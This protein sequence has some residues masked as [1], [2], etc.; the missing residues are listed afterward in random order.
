MS[1]D[2]YC[3]HDK[4]TADDETHEHYSDLLRDTDTLIYGRTTYQLMEN[5][6]PDVVKEPTGNQSTDDFAVLIDDIKKI[7]YSRS[8]N[9]VTWKNSELK[10][11]IVKEEILDLKNQNGKSIGV[12]SPG[13]IVQFFQLGLIDEFQLAIHPTIVGGGLPLFKNIRER[14]DLKLLKNK[15]FNCGVVIHYYECVNK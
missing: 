9:N 10:N 1:L 2:G 14:I 4:M 8:L 15:T 6:W 5:Y 13:L 3:D 12:G 7:V 11:E